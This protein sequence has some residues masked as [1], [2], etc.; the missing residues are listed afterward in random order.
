MQIVFLTQVSGI[1]K[2]FAWI[3]GKILNAIYQFVGLFSGNE[4]DGNTIANLALCIFIFT[5]VVKMLMMPLT[6]KQ[7]KFTKL[8]SKMNP[9]LTRIQA[10]YKGKRDEESLRRQQAE[11]QEVYRKYGA[12]PMSGC[13]PLLISLPILFALYKVIY[14]IPAYVTDIGNLYSGIADQV[15]GIK[16]HFKALGD[17]IQSNQLNIPF[18]DIQEMFENIA[19]V[20]INGTVDELNN[21]VN[22]QNIVNTIYRSQYQNYIV[23][24]LSKFNPTNWDAFL[25]TDVFS[26]IAS[27]VR[28][29]VDGVLQAHNMF[30][31]NIL[32]TPSIK[33]VS[34]LIPILAGGFQFLQGKI[35]GQ[36]TTADSD[37]PAAQSAKMMTTI[38][39]IMS[40]FFCLML[41]I[42]VGVYWIAT[43]IFTIIP[44]IFI[45]KYLDKTNIDEMLE[46]NAEKE[47]KRRAK[48]GVAE[49]D[50]VANVVR[51]SVN[52]TPK[53][54]DNSN[55]GKNSSRSRKSSSDYKRSTVSYSASNIAANAMLLAPREE[56]ENNVDN[57]DSKSE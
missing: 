51:T 56:K 25:T 53:S 43:S 54:Y 46:K 39:P 57:E 19:G 15:L 17:F 55:S 48:L 18:G 7:Q 33:S 41:P 49:G 16:D 20:E 2:P 8:S 23:D 12:S 45:N 50:K 24:I 42:G 6:I 26:S 27:N 44:A 30:G 37:N 52:R 35:Q 11:T 40:A 14:A 5:L 32:D 21:F 29:A 9:E 10:K 47:T 3:L 28:P 22:S 1:L 31:L 36:S 4:V 38:M 34:V 13:L